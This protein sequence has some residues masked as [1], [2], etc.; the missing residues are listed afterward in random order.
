MATAAVGLVLSLLGTSCI[1]GE[2]IGPGP[3]VTESDGGLAGGA[4]GR[5][6]T[7]G[8]GGGAGGAA[9]GSSTGGSSPGAGGAGAGTSGI[10]AQGTQHDVKGMIKFLHVQIV[11]VTRKQAN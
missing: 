10:Q 3:Q 9:G 8:R 7:G 2:A 11:R 5:G 1:Y 6:G 4:S